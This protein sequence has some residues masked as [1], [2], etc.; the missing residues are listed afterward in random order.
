MIIIIIIN[1]SM[2]FKEPLPTWY[3]LPTNIAL[4]CLKNPEI[5]SSLPI[6]VNSIHCIHSARFEGWT[7]NNKDG[8]RFT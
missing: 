7:K 2:T 5:D 3:C 8:T 6:I 1:L 4:L